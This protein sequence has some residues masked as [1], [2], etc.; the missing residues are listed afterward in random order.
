MCV[1]G[2]WASKPGCPRP[3]SPSRT[4]L[5]AAT[6]N[7]AVSEDELIIVNPYRING[8]DEE[9]ATQRPVLTIDQLYALSI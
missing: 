5:C 9:Q 3:W 6:L 7:T 1:S 2:V 8:A 4:A